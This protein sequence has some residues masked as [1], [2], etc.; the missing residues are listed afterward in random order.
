MTSSE[1]IVIDTIGRESMYVIEKTRA[2]I[3]K[4]PGIDTDLA[5]SLLMKY[6]EKLLLLKDEIDK[7]EKYDNSFFEYEFKTALHA[8]KKLQNYLGNICNE[9]DELDAS[10]MHSHIY[11]QDKRIRSAITESDT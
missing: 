8:I 3:Y 5:K 4:I 11:A 9:S 2:A 6:Q 7:S 10:I 1:K